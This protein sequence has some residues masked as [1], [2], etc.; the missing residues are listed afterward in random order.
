MLAYSQSLPSGKPTCLRAK[1]TIEIAGLPVK[2]CDVSLPWDGFPGWAWLSNI[3]PSLNHQE[4]IWPSTIINYQFTISSCYRWFS[5]MNRYKPLLFIIHWLHRL[6]LATINHHEAFMLIN[7]HSPLV[8]LLTIISHHHPHALLPPFL[9]ITADHDFP[10][11]P[12]S[13]ISNHYHLTTS[14]YHS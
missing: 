3:W 13:T 10:N 7:H 11:Q 8:T 14:W 6:L 2:N 4:T 5:V 12:S 9:T 1:S